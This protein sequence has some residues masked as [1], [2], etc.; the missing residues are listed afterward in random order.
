MV[1]AELDTSSD[2][3]K[4]SDFGPFLVT[5]PRSGGKATISTFNA[6]YLRHGIIMWVSW[7]VLGLLMIMTN[8]WF[9]YL[10]NK[11]NYIHAFLGWSIVIMNGYAAIDVILVNGVKTEGLHNVLG[12]G[13][14]GGLVVFAITGTVT[15]LLKKKLKWKTKY[16]KMARRIHKLLAFG[17]WGLSLVTMTLGMMLYI[18][19]RLLPV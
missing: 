16:V 8:R 4:H 7:F 1:W 13:T 6:H 9:A 2:F 18:N 12:L 17:F 3:D 10:T 5:L 14:A 11:S 15:L 19:T